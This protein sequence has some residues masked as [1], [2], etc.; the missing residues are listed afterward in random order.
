MPRGIPSRDGVGKDT[1][2]RVPIDLMG[3]LRLICISTSGRGSE[4]PAER[5][6]LAAFRKARLHFAH[7]TG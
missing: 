4:S 2:R 7:P 3:T 6:A 1:L 5:R